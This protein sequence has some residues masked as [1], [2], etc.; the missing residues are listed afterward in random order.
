[1]TV[2]SL[3]RSQA[4]IDGKWVGT[5][6]LK[7]MDPATGEEA[8]AVPD[9]GAPETKQAIE[10][11]Y[12][13]LPDWSRKLA[14]ERSVFLRRWYDLILQNTDALAEILTREQGKPL[15]EAKSEIIYGAAFVEFYAEEAK[16]VYGET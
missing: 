16:R 1:M 6:A 14:K 13:A 11:A 5:P 4:Y 8:G 7:V 15:A 9:M 2:N 3:T 12:R 10:A